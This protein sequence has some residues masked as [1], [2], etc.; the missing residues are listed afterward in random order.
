MPMHALLPHACADQ[1]VPV[2]SEG[3]SNADGQSPSARR[4]VVAIMIGEP[5]YKTRETLPRF[6]AKNLQQD[7][8]VVFVLEDSEN[9]GS[10]PEIDRIATADVLVISVRRKT[11][12]KSQLDVVRRFVAEGGSVVGIRTANHAFCLRKGKS[13]PEC[14]QW[15]QFDAEVF[16]GNYTGHYPN[17]QASTVCVAERS[18]D[19]RIV[20]SMGVD[21]FEQIGS[22]YRTSPLADGAHV[23]LTGKLQSSDREPFAAEPVAWTYTRPDGGHSFYT[24]LGH[25][26]EFE[27]PAFE[28]LLRG[29]IDWIVEQ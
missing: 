19:H 13:P 12:P 16:G 14:D 23:L 1:A 26:A 9:E 29:A 21:C 20:E 25:P 22:L 17:D 18:Q 11:L 28:R 7:Y 27:K 3:Q 15:P 10:F 2:H 6:A 5:E 4:P 24:S 8:D